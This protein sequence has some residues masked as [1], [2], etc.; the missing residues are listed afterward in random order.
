MWSEFVEA[1]RS[2]LQNQVVAGAVALGLVGVIAAALRNV[3]GALWSQLKRAVIVTATLDTRSD[4]FGAFVTWLD[5]QR[6]G[7][8]SRFFTVVQAPP[9]MV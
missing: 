1:L 6:F 3:P 5:D 4:L 7:Q 8:R 2:Q 9:S